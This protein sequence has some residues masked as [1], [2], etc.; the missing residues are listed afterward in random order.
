M[1]MLEVNLI[2]DRVL[3]PRRRKVL[4]W[5]MLAYLGLCGILLVVVVYF[6]TYRMTAAIDY[7]REAAAI[8]KAFH[9]AHPEEKDLIT[10]A[11]G[12]ER[13]LQADIRRVE[14]IE[15]LVERNAHLTRILLGLS[16]PMPRDIA[17]TEF[18]LDHQAQKVAFTLSYAE[19]HE[20]EAMDLFTLWNASTNLGR[21]VSD[22]RS[23]SQNRSP[24]AEMDIVNLEVEGT[25]KG[26]GS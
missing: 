25:L 23:V 18:R 11:R 2:K 22:L 5:A 26:K 16:V 15:D 9:E 13:D 8:R 19:D 14:T 10:F 21:E 3:A 24:Q 7:M 4:Y 20:Q 1:T 12:L 6:D 17:L